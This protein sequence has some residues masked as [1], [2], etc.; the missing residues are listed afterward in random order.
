M[1]LHPGSA[2]ARAPRAPGDGPCRPARSSAWRRR[3]IRHRLR[4]AWRRRGPRCSPAALRLCQAR[5]GCRGRTERSR[6]KRRALPPRLKARAQ[7]SLISPTEAPKAAPPNAVKE[8]RRTD[9]SGHWKSHSSRLL[10]R[11]KNM[12]SVLTG[13]DRQA[14]QLPAGAPSTRRLRQ[15]EPSPKC[16][17]G[18]PG[19]ADVS[20]RSSRRSGQNRRAGSDLDPGDLDP[21][22]QPVS[23]LR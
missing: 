8:H 16:R 3:P 10:E 15:S 19:G 22:E 12:Q 21:H 18:I 20:D 11:G 13:Q 1:N 4:P 6:W 17:E 2:R 23:D 5:R 7:V 14:P 9:T